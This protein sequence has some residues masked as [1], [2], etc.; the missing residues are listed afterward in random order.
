[1]P[2]NEDGVTV[3]VQRTGGGSRGTVPLCPYLH[4]PFIFTGYNAFTS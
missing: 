2:S 4:P 3:R 1:M